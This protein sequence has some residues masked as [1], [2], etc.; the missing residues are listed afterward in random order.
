MSDLE[1]HQTQNSNSYKMTHLM[2]DQRALR[3]AILTQNSELRIARVTRFSFCFVGTPRGRT[4][5][6]INLCWAVLRL[7]SLSRK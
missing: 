4:D 5:G 6:R 7:R 1:T 2:S 3:D